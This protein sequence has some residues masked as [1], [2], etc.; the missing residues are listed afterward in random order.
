M[1]AAGVK[2]IYAGVR[3]PDSLKDIA[4]TDPDR[5]IPIS[6]DITDDASVKAVVEQCSDVNLLINNAGVGFNQRYVA[7]ISFDKMRSEIEV[8]YFGTLRM[9]LAFAPVLKANGGGAIINMLT[10]LAKVNF[11]LNASYCASKAATL[12]ATQG[13]RAELASQKTLVIGVLPGTTVLNNIG[14]ILAGRVLLGLSVAGIMITATALIADYYIGAARA[15]FLGF[16]S[17][18]MGLGGVLFLS[19]GGFLADVNWRSPFLIYLLALL[20]LPLVVLV[21][22]EPNRTEVTQNSETEATEVFP[23]QIVGLTYLAALLS[24]IVFYLIPVQLPFYLKQLVN[25]TASQSGLAIALATL[26]SAGSAIAYKQIKARLSFMGIYAIAFLS[27]AVGYLVISLS[28]TYAMVL[29]GLAIAGTG[30]GLLMPNMNVCLTS[31][32]PG[33][34]RGR[35]LGGLTTALSQYYLLS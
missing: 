15:Q 35:V 4:A 26:F 13:I 7:N 6:L 33:S 11:P 20:I 30:L 34:L 22:P 25:A 18:F 16:Q 2:R 12:L 19:L 24:Q 23:W 17:G 21:L 14:M 9:C 3:N 32:T 10:M 28:P 27:M 31:V 5:I 29:V 1:Q 8:N